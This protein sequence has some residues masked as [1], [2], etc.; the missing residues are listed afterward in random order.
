MLERQIN[1]ILRGGSIRLLFTA[2]FSGLRLRVVFGENTSCLEHFVFAGCTA[3]NHTS[4]WLSALKI[5][6]NAH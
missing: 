3:G 2:R 5:G 4:N 6:L 1:E